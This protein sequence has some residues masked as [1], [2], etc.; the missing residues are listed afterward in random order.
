MVVFCPVLI[1]VFAILLLSVVE[2]GLDV[3]KLGQVGI[4]K[5][6]VRLTFVKESLS[7]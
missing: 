3:T 4:L 6:A 2:V 5:V 1:N 7:F